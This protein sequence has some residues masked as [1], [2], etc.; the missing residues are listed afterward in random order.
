MNENPKA[1]A[2]IHKPP[3]DLLEYAA[4]VEIAYAMKDGADKYGIGNYHEVPIH[5]RTYVAAALRHIGQYLNGEDRAADSGI[6]HLAHAAACM[7]ILLAVRDRENFVDDRG[8]QPRTPEQEARSQ[9]N[10]RPGGDKPGDTDWCNCRTL[11]TC[12]AY[13]CQKSRP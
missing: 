5:V 7:Q 11:G 4:Q 2:A 10:N 6:H 12:Y 3:L 1:S 9:V 13:G 8:P